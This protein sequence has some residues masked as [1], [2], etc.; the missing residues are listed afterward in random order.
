MSLKDA[1]TQHWTCKWLSLKH[2]HW[3]RRCVCEL[4]PSVLWLVWCYL[5]G[6]DLYNNSVFPFMVVFVWHQ[7]VRNL[8]RDSSAPRPLPG[9]PSHKPLELLLDMTVKNDAKRSRIYEYSHSVGTQWHENTHTHTLFV[10]GCFHSGFV[11]LSLKLSSISP[12]S[13]PTGLLSHLCTDFAIC[14]QAFHQ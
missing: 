7:R 1:L 14:G 4:V 3:K 11:C 2:T 6:T 10:F 13:D 5:M 8:L 12:L 9:L